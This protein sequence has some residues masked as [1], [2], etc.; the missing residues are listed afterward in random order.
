MEGKWT[1]RMNMG[2]GGERSGK[3]RKV[4]RVTKEYVEGR[5]RGGRNLGGEMNG[6]WG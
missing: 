5:L 1:G 3:Y 6:V 4:G 2:R